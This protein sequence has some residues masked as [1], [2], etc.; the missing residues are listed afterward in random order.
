MRASSG[1]NQSVSLSTEPRISVTT[2]ETTLTGRLRLGTGRGRRLIMRLARRLSRQSW[3]DVVTAASRTMMGSGSG[4]TRM[5]GS[6]LHRGHGCRRCVE[7]GFIARV[8]DRLCSFW[9]TCLRKLRRPDRIIPSNAR[10]LPSEPDRVA[11]SD[12]NLVP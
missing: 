5:Q 6:V 2:D 3:A 7:N 1:A 9:L 12:L 8:I 11:P 10:Q 4:L